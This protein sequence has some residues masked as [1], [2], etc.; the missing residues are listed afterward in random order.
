ML[1][2]ENHCLVLVSKIL[3]QWFSSEYC[4]LII[5]TETCSFNATQLEQGNKEPDTAQHGS[6]TSHKTHGVTF[7]VRKFFLVRASSSPRFRLLELFSMATFF[8]FYLRGCQGGFPVS[9]PHRPLGKAAV[10]SF[11][12]A[13]RHLL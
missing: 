9:T 3:Y 8:S 6:Y 7:L 10:S 1:A 13:S 11:K 12:A 2:D 5:R 4:L